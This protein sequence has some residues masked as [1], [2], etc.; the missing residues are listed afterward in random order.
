MNVIA[1]LPAYLPHL[2]RPWWLLAL[3]VLPLLVWW[4]RRGEGERTPWTQAVDAHLLPSLL[5]KST[6][7]RDTGAVWLFAVGYAIAVLALAGPAWRRPTAAYVPQAPLVVVADMSSHMRVADLK[8][9]RLLRERVKIQQLIAQRRIGQIGLVA[10]AGDAFTVAPV[11]DD[12]HSLDDLVVALAPDTMPADGQRADLAL[13]RAADLLARAGYRNGQILLLTDGADALAVQAAHAAHAQ[14]YEVDV[15]GVGTADGAP[16]PAADGQFANDASGQMQ[17]ARLDADGLRKLAKAGGG[18]YAAISSD[19]SDLA[20][21]G[22]L[23]PPRLAPATAAAREALAWRDEGPWLLLL[24][25]PLAALAFRRGWLAVVLLVAFTL[26]LTPAQAAP[27]NAWQGLWQRNDQRADHA[28][29][30]GDA[31]AAQSLASTPEQRAAAAYLQGDYA[32]A[33]ADWSQIDNADADYNRGNALAQMHRYEDAIAA[34]Q[35]ALQRRPGMPDAQANIDAVRKLLRQPPPQDQQRQP[36]KRGG[37]DQQDQQHNQQQSEQDRQDQQKQQTQQHRQNQPSNQPH[38]QPSSQ[39]QDQQQNAQQNTQQSTQKNQP[40]QQ[41]GASVGARHDQPQHQ[42]ENQPPSL[43][44]PG[45][46]S[47][48][49]PSPATQRNASA[50]SAAPQDDRQASASADAQAAQ[51]RPDAQQQHRADA[52]QRQAM[53]QALNQRGQPA[54]RVPAT[55]THET[56]AQS[57]RREA[58]QALLRRV[59]DDPGSL[60]RT[61]FAREYERRQQQGD[62]P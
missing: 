11:S 36:N 2:L 14:G 58:N 40:S 35:R 46:A 50:A 8:P 12:A 22:V 51:D 47:K 39:Q 9:S 32:G 25:L 30:S 62:S 44:Q 26:P 17:I 52:A 5:Q 18:R 7:T 29:R 27:S 4:W 21:L 56:R 1:L 41:R 48:P 13:R 20:A 61:K 59:P 53:Q 42:Q 28:L 10:F 54:S 24:L 57:E 6:A 31:K 16:L 38:A 33:A 60:L 34:W 55:A 49:Q 19:G 15:L 23:E 43:Q 37:Q 45:T 3:I